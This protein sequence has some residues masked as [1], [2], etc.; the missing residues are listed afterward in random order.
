M[1]HPDNPKLDV[2]RG[3]EARET[4]GCLRRNSL[5]R[6]YI[7]RR[8][9]GATVHTTELP[10]FRAGSCGAAALAS[11]LESDTAVHVCLRVCKNTSSRNRV[12]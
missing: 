2:E 8:E 12:L 3:K 1:S 5:G 11:A 7:W 9:C 10:S 4:E 6:K